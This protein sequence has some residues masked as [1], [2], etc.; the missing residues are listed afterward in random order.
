MIPVK[1]G[2]QEQEN[3]G[4]RRILAGITNL[5]QRAERINQGVRGA[6]ASIPFQC[7][8]CWMLNLEER[9]PVDGLDDMYVT[10]ICRENLD[11]LGGRAKSTIKAKVSSIK[12]SVQYCK[13]IRKTLFIPHRGPMPMAD[14]VGMSL[15]VELL[16]HSMIA[17]PRL[18]G[19]RFI[20]FDLM[21]RPRAT[22]TA[23]WKSS[24]VGIS[25]GSTFTMGTARVT[26]TACPTQQR[27]FGL[28]MRGAESRMGW[29]AHRNLPFGAGVLQKLL[30]LE[31]AEE[32]VNI[33]EAELA[34]EYT[35]IG[36]AVV[37]AL[38][39]SF[40]G[41][42]VFLLDL[43]SL[44]EYRA[45]GREGVLPAEP[46]RPAQ[47]LINAPHVLVTLIGEFKGELGTRKHRIALASITMSGINV[48]W[49]LE[50]LMLVRE[51][52]GCRTGP[53]FGD[54]WGRV[55]LMSEYDDMLHTLLQ[56]VQ[57]KEPEL[58]APSDDMERNYSF[59]RSFRRTATGRA[60][61]AGLDVSVQDAM[62]RWR[63]I[64][65]AKGKRP[66]LN[67]VDHYT[68]ARDL[69]PVTCRYVFVQ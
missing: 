41:P 25:E 17:R 44:W 62:N 11:A 15:A 21:R 37:L 38:C 34:R 40:R 35:K 42:E 6:H 64:E 4:I 1:K 10:C 33:Q 32:E 5:G 56:K 60:R 30:L 28:F 43:A 2:Q 61:G 45:M 48:R 14:N 67:M 58:I 16:M 12:R 63:K 22:F 23:A 9:L 18:K 69:M 55:A 26:A 47:N 27:W 29:S 31:L 13:L 66:R 51:Q 7:E 3:T 24:P 8:A 52:K 36:A 59:F 68:H 39:A 57:S 46:L 50:Q 49:W 20:Q 54:Q 19:E 65:E 53:A